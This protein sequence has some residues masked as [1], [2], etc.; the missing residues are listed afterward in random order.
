MAAIAVPLTIFCG[1]AHRSKAVPLNAWTNKLSFEQATP[2]SVKKKVQSPRPKKIVQRATVVSGSWRNKLTMKDDKPIT[3]GK[4]RSTSRVLKQPVK[5]V[6]T[7]SCAYCHD[8]ENLHHIR[9]CPKLAEKQRQQAIVAREYRIRSKQLRIE[10]A[11]KRLLERVCKAQ[12]TAESDEVVRQ[13]EDSGSDEDSGDD[14]ADEDECWTI[15]DAAIKNNKVSVRKKVSFARDDPDTLMKPL[16]CWTIL[17]AAIKNNKVS[18][19]KKVSFARDDPDTLMKPPC[20]TKIYDASDPVTAISSEEDAQVYPDE[21]EYLLR[22]RSATAWKPRRFQEEKK[23]VV[24]DKPSKKK[25]RW[26]DICDALS[27]DD[28]E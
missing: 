2:T 18:V 6:I 3:G 7:R 24:M 27:S 9:D 17:E 8:E 21:D 19:R 15:L 4:A 13:L 11:E 16:C 23:P 5:T 22:K 25:E 10:L 28:D 14:A 12:A 20:K 26:A 1:Q